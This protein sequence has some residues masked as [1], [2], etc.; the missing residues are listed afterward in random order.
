M[1]FEGSDK[2]HIFLNSVFIYSEYVK[3]IVEQLSD[4][5]GNY[6]CG[7]RRSYFLRAPHG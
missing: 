2:K 7:R 6:E 4:T 3:V 1:F 5:T